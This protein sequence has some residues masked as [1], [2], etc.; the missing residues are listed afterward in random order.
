LRRSGK[1]STDGHEAP[2]RKLSAERPRLRKISTESRDVKGKRE[3]A[4]NEG[5]DEGYGDLL[6]AYESE[7]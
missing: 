5:D 6:S 2:V 1:V 4:A 3:S 7:D